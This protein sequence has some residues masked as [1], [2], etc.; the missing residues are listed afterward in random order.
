M[1]QG[2]ISV[3]HNYNKAQL[4]GEAFVLL[5]T[6]DEASPP[7]HPSSSSKKLLPQVK[8]LRSRNREFSVD[9]ELGKRKSESSS[10]PWQ[11]SKHLLNANRVWL[12][13]RHT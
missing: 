3:L 12:H 11:R 1:T 2:V 13:A 7:L 10:R 4:V 5:H 9:N 6:P 8:A